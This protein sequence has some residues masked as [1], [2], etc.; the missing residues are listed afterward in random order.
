MVTKETQRMTKIKTAMPKAMT[1]SVRK[2]ERRLLYSSSSESSNGYFMLI[3]K[4]SKK[5]LLQLS[6]LQIVLAV[7]LLRLQ[8]FGSC[9]SLSGSPQGDRSSNV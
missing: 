4:I 2:Q 5:K 1:H 9:H 6:F 7:I 8:E 3:L